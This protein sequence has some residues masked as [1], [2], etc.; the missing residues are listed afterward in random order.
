MTIDAISAGRNSGNYGFGVSGKISLGDDVSGDQGPPSFNMYS[1]AKNTSLP[2][3][4]TPDMKII[5][6]LS[7]DSKDLDEMVAGFEKEIRSEEENLVQS[8]KSLTDG[9]NLESELKRTSEKLVG[10][11]YSQQNMVVPYQSNDRLGFAWDDRS[12]TKEKLLIAAELIDVF[13]GR[14]STSF[15]EQVEAMNEDELNAAYG[16][17]RNARDY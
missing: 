4:Y 2:G 14:G 11:P 15:V 16:A 9:M 10:I 6:G 5:T 3:D 17:T 8:L 12:S 1:I 7:N 13:V